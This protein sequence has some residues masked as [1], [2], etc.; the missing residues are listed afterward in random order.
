M[1]NKQ[2]EDN[3]ERKRRLKKEKAGVDATDTTDEQRKPERQQQKGRS[4][5]PK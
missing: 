2:G 3:G 1:Y 5:S 4:R